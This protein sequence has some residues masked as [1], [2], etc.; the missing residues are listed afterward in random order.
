MKEGE[1]LQEEEVFLRGKEGDHLYGEWRE[2]FESFD[3]AMS[4]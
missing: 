4:E 3:K 1:T 2:M